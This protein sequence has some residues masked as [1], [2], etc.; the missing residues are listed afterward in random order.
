MSKGLRTYEHTS[1]QQVKTTCSTLAASVPAPKLP[2]V[3]TETLSDIK[4]ND[5]KQDGE[6]QPRNDINPGEILKPLNFQAVQGCT[7]NISLNFKQ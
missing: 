5:F 6:F 1:V 7:F 4:E 3:A 2:Y